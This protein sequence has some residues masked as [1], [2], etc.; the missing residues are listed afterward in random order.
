MD[1]LTTI[2]V[3]LLAIEVVLITLLVTLARVASAL[4]RIAN[5]T[6]PRIADSAHRISGGS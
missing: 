1:S 2:C 4:E 6:L 5:T 3:L